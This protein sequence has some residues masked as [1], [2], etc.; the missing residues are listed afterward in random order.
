M[1]FSV[2]GIA[3][4]SEVMMTS[5]GWSFRFLITTGIRTCWIPTACMAFGSAFLCISVLFCTSTCPKP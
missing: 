5:K 3:F 1:R 2:K 4:E